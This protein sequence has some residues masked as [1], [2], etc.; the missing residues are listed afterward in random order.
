MKTFFIALAAFIIG[1][2]LALGI[3]YLCVKD[4]LA[5]DNS[6]SQG[7]EVKDEYT[8]HMVI[9]FENQEAFDAY[10]NDHVLPLYEAGK[11]SDMYAIFEGDI[12][13]PIVDGMVPNA[14][15]GKEII[16]YK[17]KEAK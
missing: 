3:G 12:E 1:A 15:E 2:C 9:D 11:L 4:N 5:W 6:P 13:C 16:G 14:P 10:F 7:E 8:I 17:Y